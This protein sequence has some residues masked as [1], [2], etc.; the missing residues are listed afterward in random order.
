MKAS[1]GKRQQ[2]EVC[3]YADC[4]NVPKAQD[5]CMKHYQRARR[6][7]HIGLS[8]EEIIEKQHD[9]NLWSHH[10]IRLVDAR[11][12]WVKQGMRCKCCFIEGSAIYTPN[13]D[14]VIDHDR[15]CC[16]TSVKRE[17][18]GSCTRGIICES[19]NKLANKHL[20]E[21]ERWLALGL[22]LGHMEES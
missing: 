1:N 4:D 2:T 18:G 13:R 10:R 3:I 21:K 20:L 12:M 17:C 5:Y 14:W 16:P 19:C 9:T 6:R 8:R 11:V 15:K 22:Y 7:G